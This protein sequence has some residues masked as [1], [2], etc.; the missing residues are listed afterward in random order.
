MKDVTPADMFKAINDLK[1]NIRDLTN[2]SELSQI[3][4][5]KI[6]S[7][8]TA[9]KGKSSRIEKLILFT[10]KEDIDNIKRSLKS[11]Q[12]ILEGLEMKKGD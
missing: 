4:R 6:W 12:V 2:K 5:D 1:K 3:N 9:I 8:I 11:E 10:L 7:E